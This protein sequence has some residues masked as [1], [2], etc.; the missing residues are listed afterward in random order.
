MINI[1]LIIK[2]IINYF[3]QLLTLPHLLLLFSLI[4]PLKPT[5]FSINPSITS[6]FKQETSEFPI[7][8]E[9][10]LFHQN[11]IL[12]TPWPVKRYLLPTF[13]IT[14]SEREKPGNDKET[15]TSG[16]INVQFNL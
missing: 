10:H 11:L 12:H 13:Q 9:I 6:Y 4:V 1:I 16:S 8:H 5:Y 14:Y 7:T 15:T 2:R 3:Y